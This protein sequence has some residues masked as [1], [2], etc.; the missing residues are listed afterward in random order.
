MA[1]RCEEDNTALSAALEGSR[2]CSTR[3]RSWAVCKWVGEL[4]GLGVDPMTGFL[5][6]GYRLSPEEEDCVED[7]VGAGGEMVEAS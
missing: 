5:V 6:E 7:G 3:G 2:V 4:A 1:A